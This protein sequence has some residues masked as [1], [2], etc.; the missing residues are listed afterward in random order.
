MSPGGS[1][2]DLILT[3]AERLEGE[4]GK[5]VWIFA[6]AQSLGRGACVDL[7]HENFAGSLILYS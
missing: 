2:L 7:A 5:L 6:G 3:Q 1:I 4:N